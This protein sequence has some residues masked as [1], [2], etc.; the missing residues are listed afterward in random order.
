MQALSLQ[1]Q[2]SR[3]D[4]IVLLMDK[5]K[6]DNGNR[7]KRQKRNFFEDQLKN[8]TARI[9]RHYGFFDLFVSPFTQP[10]TLNAAK[11]PIVQQKK[12]K[13]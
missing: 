4:N 13:R 2:I 11:G 5:G 10:K 8:M 9:S 6:N 7:C 12:Y 3:H 1:S